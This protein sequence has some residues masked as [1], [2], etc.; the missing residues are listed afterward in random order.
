MSYKKWT[1]SKGDQIQLQRQP[2]GKVTVE[3]F[4]RG[5]GYF[6]GSLPMVTKYKDVSCAMVTRATYKLSDEDVA[7]ITQYGAN[8]K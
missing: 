8:L 5:G 2:S 7:M 4:D 6:F 1:N 3:V